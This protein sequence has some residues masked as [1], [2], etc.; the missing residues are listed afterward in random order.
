MLPFELHVPSTLD[1]ALDLLDQHQEDGRPIAGGT[2]L[3]LLMQQRL[4]LPDHLVS[5]GRIPELQRTDVSNGTLRIG[6]AVTHRALEKNPEVGR[7]WPLLTN[8][9]H[10]VATVRVRNVA[11]VGGGLAHADPNQD[12]PAALIALNARVVARSRGGQREIPIDEL[13]T[14]YY[15]TVLQPGELITEVRL[16]RPQRPL[17]TAYLKFLPR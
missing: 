16:P 14:G 13:F 6:A 3:T 5:L 15:E 12:P 9:Y 4:V 1:E 8:T 11:T 2:A 17:K 10:R 7:T